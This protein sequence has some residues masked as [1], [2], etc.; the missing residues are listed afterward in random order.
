MQNL[1]KLLADAGLR[2]A[3]AVSP[4]QQTLLKE[5]LGLARK[6]GGKSVTDEDRLKRLPPEF[7]ILRSITWG[8]EFMREF[9]RLC[10]SHPHLINRDLVAIVCELAH[11]T[12]DGLIE[13]G[14]GGKQKNFGS[15]RATRD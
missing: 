7:E 11:K 8:D 10:Q 9:A 2:G 13:A 15:M 14:K 4:P 3:S 5:I 12:R 6:S 1:G